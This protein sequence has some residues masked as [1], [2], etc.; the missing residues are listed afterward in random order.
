MR[1]LGLRK[2]LRIARPLKVVSECWD[3]AEDSLRNDVRDDYPGVNEEFITQM[4][5][6]KLAKA[7][8]T[9]SQERRVEQ[10][11]LTDLRKAFPDLGHA[12]KLSSRARGLIADV[13][14][15]RRETERVTGGDIGFMI[16][17]PQINDRGNIIDD[18]RRG[19]LCQAKLKRS[20]G[21]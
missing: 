11:F 21:K 15:H 16:I 17:R 6:G 13:T 1:Y 7:L 20:N 4:F 19:L 9:A 18:Y 12:Y 5:H 3:A 10:A 14:L 8:R 2:I